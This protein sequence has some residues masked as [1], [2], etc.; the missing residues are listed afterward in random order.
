MSQFSTFPSTYSIPPAS[1]YNM[2]GLIGWLNQNPTYKQ[3][4]INYPTITPGL[5]PIKS[6]LNNSTM[7]SSSSMMQYNVQNAPLQPLVITMSYNQMQQY[8]E[9]LQLFRR[10]YEFNSNAYI[11]S[12]PVGGPI[13]Y[14]FSSYQEL[15]SY[16]ASVGIVN[17]LYPF[18]PMAYGK[19]EQG[20]ALNWIVPFPL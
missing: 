1:F 13:Y 18:K 16:K 19:N 11:R 6:T 10:V 8:N 7:I 14:S 2:Q 15:M 4:F 5:S 20:Q 17:K 3:Y 9:Q 12:L